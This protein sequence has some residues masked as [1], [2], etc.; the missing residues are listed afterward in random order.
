M[1]Q[2]QI[3]KKSFSGSIGAGMKSLV[4]SEGRRFYILEHKVS[5]RY[6]KA[7]ETQRIIV[8]QIELGRDSHCQVRFDE[9][10]ETVSRRH[11][12][13]VK[14][15]DNW[16]L[17][18]LSKVNSTYL[19]GHKIEKEWYL[20]SG[21]EIQLS[22]NGPKL[23]FIVPQGDKSL[24]KSIGLT[25]R[26]N[27]FRQQALRPYKTAIAVMAAVLLLMIAGISGWTYQLQQ[28][29]NEQSIALSKAINANLDNQK[30]A[31]SL[32]FE[33]KENNKK[34]ARYDKEFVKFIST[35]DKVKDLDVIITGGGGSEQDDV[36]FCI[37]TL[38]CDGKPVSKS[39]G[40]AFL[41]NDGRLVTAQ[42]VVNPFMGFPESENHAWLLGWLYQ[43]PEHFT[44]HFL[45][46]SSKGDKIE[47]DYPFSQNQFHT[48][49]YSKSNL[50]TITNGDIELSVYCIL[51]ADDRDYAWLQTNKKG[52]LVAD[53]VYSKSLRAKTHLDI[54]GFP[55]GVG[56]EDINK[57]SPIYSES[58]VAREGL[59]VDGCILLSNSETDHG[60]SG[61]PVLAVKDGK[62]VVVGILSG[63]D[64]L[65][66][67]TIDW[68]AVANMSEEDQEAF[69]NK[70]NSAKLKGR[71]VPISAIY[72]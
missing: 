72:K 8:D 57:V 10:F 64:R 18:Q 54:Y 16:K 41:L 36:Y 40:T 58:H 65:G 33:L 19:N 13:I 62:L 30:R 39:S 32:A 24:V 9:S 22:T 27:L 15:G 17:I 44:C 29:Y 23:G 14:D 25:A 61:G 56:A 67:K 47:Y 34:L 12:A 20:Q 38:E 43:A 45:A 48:G 35:R 55:Q 53:A 42:H 1:A 46:V 49:K 71:V 60:N 66:S 63:A 5:S 4:G 28:K 2:T 69:K 52:R 3:Y 51:E 37:Y 68:E 59:D 7:G 31:D 21:D 11:A 26:M 70:I 50:G 6:H